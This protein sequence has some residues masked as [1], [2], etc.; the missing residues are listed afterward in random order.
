LLDENWLTGSRIFFDRDLTK[1]L[2][3]RHAAILLA[4][5]RRIVSRICG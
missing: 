3:I 1:G 4:E 5:D 2:I